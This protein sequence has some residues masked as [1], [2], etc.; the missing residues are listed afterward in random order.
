VNAFVA[1]GEMKLYSA[2]EAATRLGVNVRTIQGWC[3]KDLFPNAYKLNP[4][5]L[6][7]HWRIPEEDIAAFEEKRQQR[8]SATTEK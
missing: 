8:P 5:G 4:T 7:S 2:Q 1:G 3:K 6:T